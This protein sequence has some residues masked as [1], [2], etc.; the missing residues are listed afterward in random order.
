MSVFIVHQHAVHAEHT[1][2]LPMLYVS[3]SNAG[4]VAER[5]HILSLFDVLVGATF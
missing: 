2:V 3:P 5:M 4:T 1:I